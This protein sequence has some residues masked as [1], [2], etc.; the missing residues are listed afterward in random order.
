MCTVVTG[1]NFNTIHHEMGHIE[2]YMAYKDQPT[3]FKTGANSAFHEAIGDTI[4]LSVQTDKHLKAI[5]M[6]DDDTLTDGIV[7]S[8]SSVFFFNQIR[9]KTYWHIYI[10]IKEQ[11]INFLMEMALQK[12]VFLPF[13]YL[14]DNWRW[15]VFRGEIDETNYNQKWWE[16]RSVHALYF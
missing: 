6:I 15:K 10:C 2:Y 5:K 3:I 7:K 13:A 4:S 9:F 8:L 14:M 1:D 16:M 11:S 12:V